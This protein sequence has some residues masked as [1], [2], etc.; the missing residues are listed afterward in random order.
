MD[1]ISRIQSIISSD[2]VRWRLLEIV[3]SLKLPDCWIGAGFVRNAVWD[4]LH[5][6]APSPVS[7][8]VDV[9][10]FDAERCTPEEDAAFEAVLSGLKPTVKWSV[11]QARMHIEGGAGSG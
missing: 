11:N 7:T 2:P 1:D 6:R 4:Y 3:D 8:D 10:W 9:I 5:G